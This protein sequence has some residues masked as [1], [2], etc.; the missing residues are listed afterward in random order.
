M[1]RSSPTRVIGGRYVLLERLGRGGAGIVWRA[2]DRV[3]GREVAVKELHLRGGRGPDERRLFRDRLLQAARAA[4]RLDHP[5]VVT[6]H[7]VVTD[8]DVDHIVMELVEAPTLADEVAAHRRLDERTVTGVAR[9]L[10]AALQAI[11]AAGVAHGDITPR[12]VV[13]GPGAR[14]RLADLG[15]ADAADELRLTRPPEFL[16]PEL[17]E[18]GPATPESDLW[19]L[20]ATLYSALHGR[21][22]FAM[23][24]REETLAA[25]RHAEV[26]PAV[27]AGPLGAVLAG[28]LQRTPQ[29]R[30][31]ALQVATHLDVPGVPV[32]SGP[33]R[34][35]RWGWTAAAV[36]LGL[37]AGSAAGFALVGAGGPAVTTLTHGVDGDVPTTAASEGLCLRDV[38]A[39]ASVPDGALVPCAGPHGSEVFAT[40]DPYGGRS[41]PDPGREAV[42][43]YAELACTAAFEAAVAPPD[44]RG[45]AIVALVPSS[46]EFESGRREVHC[47]L[48]AEDGTPLTGSR[49]AGQP[50]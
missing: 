23:G 41:V 28:L 30:L 44:R 2:E 22:P 35:T 34:A 32:P 33:G 48:G 47:L 50:G 6:V 8:D 18:G 16:A 10:A 24:T 31:T 37:V 4:S 25:V 20:G 29:A 38:P 1:T 9:K 13:L 12:N 19:A 49:I 5:G 14:V 3:T 17:L 27:T 11:H 43:G 26:A 15:V 46:A 7:D 39:R 21:S 42:A 45:L 40:L 36:V